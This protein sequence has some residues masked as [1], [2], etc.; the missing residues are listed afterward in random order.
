[1]GPFPGLK[2]DKLWAKSQ[3]ILSERRI[4]SKDISFLPCLQWF[5]LRSY[6]LILFISLKIN[7]AGNVFAD[8]VS[9]KPQERSTISVNLAVI[10]AAT[11]RVFEAANQISH[12]EGHLY[13]LPHLK[14]RSALA[15]RTGP[16]RESWQSLT[17]KLLTSG[18]APT[19]NWDQIRS[20]DGWCSGDKTNLCVVV[21]LQPSRAL[22]PS[23][24]S[25]TGI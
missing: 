19:H 5:S 25:I 15:C 11:Y 4:V 17:G 2:G 23:R 14:K 1:M 8:L 18:W 22:L 10:W 3:E 20:G 7:R 16:G 21:V 6:I 24:K 9:V 12:R 13:W